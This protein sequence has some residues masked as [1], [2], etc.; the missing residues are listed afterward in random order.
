MPPQDKLPGRC[1]AAAFDVFYK[2]VLSG[3]QTFGSVAY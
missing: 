3:N 2:C 1:K